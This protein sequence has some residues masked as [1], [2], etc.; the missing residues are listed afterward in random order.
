MAYHQLVAVAPSAGTRSG[1]LR[2]REAVCCGL[3]KWCPAAPSRVAG[4][5][6]W[7]AHWGDVLRQVPLVLRSPGR[8]TAVLSG[9]VLTGASAASAGAQS[10]EYEGLIGW[11]LSL[12]E[13]IGEVGVGLAVLIETFFPPIPS[14][15]MLPGAGFLAYEGRMS[16]WG[17]FLA[18]T[19]A[20]VLGAVLWYALGAALGPRRTRSVLG[21]IPLMEVEDV[22]RATDFFDRWGGLAVLIGRCVPLVRSVISIP[23]GIVRMNLARF[24]LYTAIGSAVWNG[25]WVGLGFAFGP[26]IQPALQQWSRVLS[27]ITIA[28]VVAAVVVFIVR[29]TRRHR[30]RRS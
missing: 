25:I 6:P 23:A 27:N 16:F 7:R 21:R 22:D 15:V 13:R 17:A 29:R 1:V 24:V 5:R 19:L 18:A 4:A 28:L 9:A 10:A 12:M 30:R 11:V 2:A 14:E 20:S 3:T 8:T 26:A